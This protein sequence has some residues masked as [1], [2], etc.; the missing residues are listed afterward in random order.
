[1]TEETVEMERIKEELQRDRKQ[2]ENDK[3]LAKTEVQH[4]KEQMMKGIT[5]ATGV[6]KFKGS[7]KIYSCLSRMIGQQLE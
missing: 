6:H 5:A 1:M 2:F 3:D 7:M 4:K